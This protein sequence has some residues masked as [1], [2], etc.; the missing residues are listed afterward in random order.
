MGEIQRWSEERGEQ[1]L[2]DLLFKVGAVL[3]D[4]EIAML[5][6]AFGSGLP[7]QNALLVVQAL[8]DIGLTEANRPYHMLQLIGGED[9]V[10]APE[11]MLS[12]LLG[13]A[14]I[15]ED[16]GVNA[17]E[18]VDALEKLGIPDSPEM[19]SALTQLGVKVEGSKKW[20]DGFD[21]FDALFAANGVRWLA[22]R[23][24][25]LP[26]TKISRNAG[27]YARQG[28]KLGARVLFRK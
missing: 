25:T 16:G 5:A 2:T 1:R 4:V 21:L 24:R 11:L 15:R 7:Q 18:I 6:D 10:L 14:R 28:L 26:W 13:A 3:S 12:L 17:D 23:A 27:R 9:G 19:K 22:S 20:Y 8:N